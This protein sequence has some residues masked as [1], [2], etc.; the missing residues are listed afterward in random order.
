MSAKSE[1]KR[2]QRSSYWQVVIYKLG[3]LFVAKIVCPSTEFLFKYTPLNFDRKHGVDT[4]S[5]VSGESLSF[6]GYS[7]DVQ[8][9]YQPTCVKHFAFAMIVVPGSFEDWSFVD[10]G[11]G[12]GRAV[13]LAMGYPFRKVMGVE[14]VSELHAIAQANLDRYRGPRRCQTVEL[15]CGDATAMPLPP[16]D[17]VIFL[18]NS[19]GGELLNRL[20]DHLEASLRQM[21]RRLLLIY[22]NPVEREAV[23]SR[24]AFTVLFDG[25]SPQELI[26]W[27]NRRLVVYGAG[28]ERTT[29][30][31]GRPR[32]V[33]AGPPAQR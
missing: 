7:I 14:L 20:L 28:L 22:S 1:P 21:S 10:I 5:E 26:W 3:V 16:G 9:G 15:V 6:A 2:L 30:S 8:R 27:G 11:S 31:P 17:V 4:H 32:A 24:A 23:E 12:K 18:Y 19:F 29:V 33:S 13:L 25:A